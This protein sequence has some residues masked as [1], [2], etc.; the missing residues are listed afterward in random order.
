MV[1]PSV[2]AVVAT[3]WK[4]GSPMSIL[5]R[6]GDA[7]GFAMEDRGSSSDSDVATAAEVTEGVEGLLLCLGG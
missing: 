7:G 1:S 6:F 5:P 3:V 4:S 2:D